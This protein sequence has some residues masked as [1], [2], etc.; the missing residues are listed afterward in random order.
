MVK[1]NKALTAEFV[2]QVEEPP[3]VAHVT[4]AQ[5]AA[6][7]AAEEPPVQAAHVP[8]PAIAVAPV[9]RVA[10]PIWVPQT[11]TA[12]QSADPSARPYVVP[13]MQAVQEESAVAVPAT[14]RGSP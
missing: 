14:K 6:S 10:P 1:N 11:V 9:K 5:L 4:A 12:A 13:A 3:A 8:G 2:G 7:E